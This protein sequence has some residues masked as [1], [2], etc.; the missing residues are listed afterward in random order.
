MSETT[1]ATTTDNKTSAA[2]IAILA[3]IIVFVLTTLNVMYLIKQ[4][5]GAGWYL[6][7]TGLAGLI[8]IVIWPLLTLSSIS[9]ANALILTLI[10][11]VA[12]MIIY[13]KAMYKLTG[14]L[15]KTLGMSKFQPEISNNDIKVK[16]KNVSIEVVS[17][18]TGGLILHF[19][20]LFVVVILINYAYFWI[21]GELDT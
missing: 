11:V 14:N 17:P 9:T 21:G 5:S 6:Y 4:N 2:E 16:D 13:S 12:G 8:F 10:L 15:F 18:T 20:V 1:P 3:Y 19:I 7:Y